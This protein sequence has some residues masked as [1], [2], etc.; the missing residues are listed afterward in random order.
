VIVRVERRA[1]GGQLL[2]IAIDRFDE[3]VRRF[4]SFLSEHQIAP[5]PLKFEQIGFGGFSPHNLAPFLFLLSIVRSCSR[6]IRCLRHAAIETGRAPESNHQILVA[7]HAREL[8]LV[9]GVEMWARPSGYDAS[10]LRYTLH[11]N[12]A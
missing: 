2:H 11:T 6:P 7:P 1:I 10:F 4:A 9:V 3:L 12:G 5:K 8:L